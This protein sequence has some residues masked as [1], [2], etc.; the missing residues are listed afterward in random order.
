MSQFGMQMPG[1][2]QSRRP[3]VDV[4]TGLSF[5]AFVCLAAACAVVWIQGSKI[6]PSDAGVMA[7]LSIHEGSSVKLPALRD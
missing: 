2:R 3:S 7:P 5:L 4:Y 1:S 6:G